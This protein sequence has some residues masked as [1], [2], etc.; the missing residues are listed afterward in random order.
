MVKTFGYLNVLWRELLRTLEWLSTRIGVEGWQP[1]V[2]HQ[3][4][5]LSSTG[6]CR[7]GELGFRR[8]LHVPPMS[9]VCN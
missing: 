9:P 7:A 5:C 8:I 6:V 1:N 3:T 4:P 2:V